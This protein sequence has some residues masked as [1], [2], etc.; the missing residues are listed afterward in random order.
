MSFLYVSTEDSFDDEK[1]AH[2]PK[3]LRIHEEFLG[4]SIH[5]QTK[6]NHDCIAKIDNCLVAVIGTIEQ[7][8]PEQLLSRYLNEGIDVSSALFGSFVVLIIHG[9]RLF[10]I[11]DPIGL[12]TVYYRE[13]EE[14]QITISTD[15]VGLSVVD[16]KE[17]KHLQDMFFHSGQILFGTQ[18]WG[19][20]MQLRPGCWM[21]KFKNHM[22]QQVSYYHLPT[23]RQK[24][25]GL[26][27]SIYVQTLA[28]IIHDT[29]HVQH[30]IPE[31]NVQTLVLLQALKAQNRTVT[32]YGLE[33]ETW[34]TALGEFFSMPVQYIQKTESIWEN[35]RATRWY[36]G[37]PPSNPQLLRMYTLSSYL[38]DKDVYLSTEES[39]GGPWL[40]R[41]LLLL[42]YFS[43]QRG[44]AYLRACMGGGEW[45]QEPKA[46]R[47]RMRT[48]KRLQTQLCADG[49]D[50][51][52]GAIQMRVRQ[53]G[54]MV[55]LPILRSLFPHAEIPLFD[56]R[57]VRQSLC[58][59]QEHVVHR[60]R[61]Q[62]WYWSAFTKGIDEPVLSLFQ[63]YSAS[64]FEL[65]EECR[66]KARNKIDKAPIHKELKH[67]LL[68][69]DN[70]QVDRMLWYIAQY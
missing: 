12:R 63:E 10:V 48:A 57:L 30:M 9:E 67:T 3:G 14:G 53:W 50:N 19:H 13:K 6:K 7:C 2:H 56:E 27:R 65:D 16:K 18:H 59:P 68:H 46:L 52:D 5:I 60:G 34:L 35:I 40:Q 26:S 8:T 33:G 29:D 61:V 23:H 11:R 24:S 54:G 20:M 17:E 25:R 44:E 32:L 66:A 70:K 38:Q 64:Q 37:A 45:S 1:F 47:F 49:Q 69:R 15:P 31:R 22:T 21:S 51:V 62:H 58:M 4:F 42:H 28:R 55:L 43:P 41:F 39:F 36:G